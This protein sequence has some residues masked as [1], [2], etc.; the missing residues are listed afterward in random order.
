MPGHF[1]PLFYSRSGSVIGMKLIL[2]TSLFTIL[3][4]QVRVGEWAAYTSSLQ[5]NDLVEKDSLLICATNGGV[6][7]YDRDRDLFTTYTKM[8]GLL[9]TNLNQLSVDPHGQ[10]WIGGA[11]PN[12]F[13]QILSHNFVVQKTLDMNL[14]E[15]ADLALSDSIA[16]AVFLDNQD[17]GIM[18]LRYDGDQYFYK[19]VYTN[20][21]TS[22]N[23]I[24]AILL[25]HELLFVATDRGLFIGNWVTTNLKNPDNWQ[26]LSFLTS[27]ITTF[28][29]DGDGILLV[30]GRD[31]YHF[32]PGDTAA[33]LIWDHYHDYELQLVDVVRDQ[34]GNLVG[35]RRQHFVDM[36][37]TGVTWQ[38]RLGIDLY[39]ISLLAD[40]QLAIGAENGLIVV[41]QNERTFD[42]QKPNG[43]VTNLVSAIHVLSDGRMV[44]GSRKGLMIKEN[45][46]WRNIVGTNRDDLRIHENKD[47]SKFVADTIPVHF[48][49]YIADLEEG[50]DGL[51]YCSIRGT[52]PEPRR[53]GGGI[54]IIDIDD[55][56]NFTLI[57]T[58]HLDYFDDEYMV[59][60]DV[61]R[62]PFNN[63]WIADT[64]ATTR[65]EPLKVLQPDSTWGSFSVSESGG[66]LSLTP[67]TIDFDSWGRVWI[68]SFEDD[69]NIASARDG[70]LVMLNYSGDPAAPDDTEWTV[71]RVNADATTNT[72]WSIGISSQDVLYSLTPKGLNGLYLQFSDDDPVSSYSRI[73]YPNIAFSAGSRL[74][75]DPMDNVWAC[76]PSEG[77]YILTSSAGYWPDINGITAENSYL[78]SN[79]VSAVAFD[80]QKGLAYI[81]TS[82]GINVLK[83]PFA[84]PKTSYTS[85]T[86]FPSPYDIPS[87]I[88]LTID[89]LKPNSSCKIMTMTGQVLQTIN[90]QQ[91]VEGYQAFW[92]GKDESGRWVGT[93][94]YLI[95][96]YDESGASSFSKIA[97]I[98]N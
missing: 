65:H 10:I 7:V 8:D 58:A 14:T 78:L 86:V 4:A 37:H 34:E 41:D 40:G 94:V 50:S 62:D 29:K 79:E 11:S 36:S 27:A 77:I 31:I 26:H 96:A 63:L 9:G 24:A 87:P 68:G 53:H 91:E 51:L 2:L 88:P 75:I 80:R 21:P 15:I 33:K 13:L 44:A 5:I 23:N 55:P 66:A 59:V 17:W 32:T 49:N 93:G 85:V 18:E 42:Y 81:A 6:L 84:E 61:A 30:M 19:D 73:Y 69:N 89:G 12:G 1:H 22:I 72:V 3:T 64:Y 74:S 28:K 56:A 95:A 57:D 35:I 20:W 60:K 47:Y 52:Y 43:L 25:H 70:G 39:N 98:R 82:K 45:A 83:I 54:V 76:S 16:F 46:G 67:N 38:R 71:V 97:V 90:S 48:G 92:D